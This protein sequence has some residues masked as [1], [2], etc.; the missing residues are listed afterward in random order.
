[1]DEVSSP[2]II[3]TNGGTAV[4]DTFAAV[5]VEHSSRCIAQSSNDD[6][7]SNIP[8]DVV[9]IALSSGFGPPTPR[10]DIGTTASNTSSNDSCVEQQSRNI[11]LPSGEEM[12]CK[13]TLQSFDAVEYHHPVTSIHP[14]T[15]GLPDISLLSLPSDL[16]TLAHTIIGTPVSTVANTPNTRPGSGDHDTNTTTIHADAVVAVSTIP[17]A[18]AYVIPNHRERR[19][20][21]KLH[22]IAIGT[23]IVVLLIIGMII[24]ITIPIL[25]SSPRDEKDQ[26][27]KTPPE[28]I[29]DYIYQYI[30]N[31]T[32]SNYSI[33]LLDDQSST[34]TTNATAE[35]ASLHWL[36]ANSINDPNWIAFFDRNGKGYDDRAPENPLADLRQHVELTQ[37]YV[38]L[39][40]WFQQKD[41]WTLEFA[42][43][44]IHTDGWLRDTSVC[45]WY[46]IICEDIDLMTL[47]WNGEDLVDDENMNHTTST[48]TEDESLI[49]VVTQILF[50][51]DGP[52]YA[53]N[54][55]NMNDEVNDEANHEVTDEAKDEVLWS[56]ILYNYFTVFNGN[57][58]SGTIPNDIGLLTHLRIM[59]FKSNRLTG[60]I[61]SSLGLLSSLVVFDVSN[62]AL[63]GPIPESMPQLTGLTYF[64]ISYN[65]VNG[66]IP[67]LFTQFENMNRFH[68]TANILSGT[69]PELYWTDIHIFDVSYNRL[70]GTIPESIQEWTRLEIFL[71]MG[72][73]FTGT[74]PTWIDV[75]SNMTAYSIAKNQF[76]GTIPSSIQSWDSA[77]YIDLSSNDIHGALPLLSQNSTLIYLNVTNNKMNGTFPFGD[78]ACDS[79]LYFSC[80]KNYFS[81]PVPN[82]FES[83]MLHLIEFEVAYNQLTGTLPDYLFQS[84]SLQRLSAANNDF[85]GTLPATID[86]SY[87]FE[88][89]LQNNMLVGTLPLYIEKWTNLALLDV[90]GNDFTGTIPSQLGTGWSYPTLLLHNNSFTGNVSEQLCYSAQL[91]VV[92]CDVSC[93]CCTTCFQE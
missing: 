11:M 81:G 54:E 15:D 32:L 56:W 80:G 7:N 19:K 23:G 36:I 31:I 13:N 21:S 47:L 8:S 64:D 88:I 37:R 9:A 39:I 41:E 76:T 16:Q 87:L 18:E 10:V 58:F 85:T 90:S 42:E 68:A 53:V 48:G 70:N 2:G 72:N 38:L 24:G 55:V 51:S 65:N 20:V 4:I 45:T 63:S 77:E 25:A 69:I 44:W 3:A 14:P 93:T 35:E 22:Y 66:T 92:D 84:T 74:I 12:N 67:S 61:P 40:F 57:A 82:G 52:M 33:H 73:T 30:N 83:C 86:E 26:M 62:N 50:L 60:T 75:F 71:V 78:G 1:M 29:S 34:N 91:V 6:T 46:G 17:E 49:S 59:N 89:E 28:Y 79:L 5:E 43:S 27:F